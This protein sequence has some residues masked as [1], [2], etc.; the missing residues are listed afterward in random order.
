MVYPYPLS[1]SATKSHGDKNGMVISC[2]QKETTR[3]VAQEGAP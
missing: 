2:S 3:A 1:L